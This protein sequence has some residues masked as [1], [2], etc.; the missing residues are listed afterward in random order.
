MCEIKWNKRKYFKV[1]ELLRNKKGEKKIVIMICEV[2]LL[3]AI[4]PQ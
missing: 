1:K 3:S 4:L 2:N